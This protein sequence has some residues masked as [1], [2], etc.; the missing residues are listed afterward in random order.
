[1]LVEKSNKKWRMCVDFTDLN[2]ACPKD[3]FPHPRI[4]QLVDNA[5]GHELL[6]FMG[7]FSGQMA[8]ED[9]EAFIID[10]DTFYYKMMPFGVKNARATFQRRKL[11]DILR[12]LRRF[13]RYWGSTSWNSTWPN[14]C[15]EPP[16]VNSWASSSLLRDRRKPW[17]DRS[18]I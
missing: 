9:R 14:L 10:R 6:S 13:S 2:K 16:R 1:M 15:L 8:L 11:L 4:D 18:N 17:E 12:I 5:S 3:N 7:A